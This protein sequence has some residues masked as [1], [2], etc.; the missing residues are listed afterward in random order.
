MTADQ[1]H[2]KRCETCEFWDKERFKKE[3]SMWVCNKGDVMTNCIVIPECVPVVIGFA[4][5]ILSILSLRICVIKDDF[6]NMAIVERAMR[7]FCSVLGL[8]SAGRCSAHPDPDA[9]RGPAHKCRYRAVTPPSYA[10]ML[11]PRQ[12]PAPR[13][14]PVTPTCPAPRKLPMKPETPEPRT[15]PWREK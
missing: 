11:A 2:P 8:E 12:A 1:P 13:K 10:E 5:L 6:S 15:R 7:V 9:G 4:T 14:K 3:P